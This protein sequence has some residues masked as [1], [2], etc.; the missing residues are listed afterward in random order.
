MFI[1]AD[2]ENIDNFNVIIEENILAGSLYSKRGPM[3][4]LNYMLMGRKQC[5]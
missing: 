1:F 5:T 4:S 2:S 3:Y